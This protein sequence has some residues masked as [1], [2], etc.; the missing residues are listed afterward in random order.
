MKTTRCLAIVL[1]TLIAADSS[2]VHSAAAQTSNT[3]VRPASSVIAE[4]QRSPTEKS[5]DALSVGSQAAE[6]QQAGR[7]KAG[8]DLAMRRLAATPEDAAALYDAGAAA[9][10]VI[11]AGKQE[12]TPQEIGQI[13]EKGVQNL[14]KAI[15]RVRDFTSAMIYKSKLYREQSKLVSDRNEIARLQTLAAA[16]MNDAIQTKRPGTAAVFPRGAFASPPIVVIPVELR[17]EDLLPPGTATF[18]AAPTEV[19]RQLARIVEEPRAT[20][21]AVGQN[22]SLSIDP[23]TILSPNP[24]GYDIAPFLI[25]MLDRLRFS[26]YAVMPEAARRGEKG[27][28]DFIFTIVRDG[29]VQDVKLILTSGNQ[30]LDQAAEAAIQRSRFAPIPDGFKGDQFTLRVPFLYN[31]NPGER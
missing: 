6:Y 1:A 3:A 26:W 31:M 4:L 29:T 8:Y 27:R 23:P 2:G 7:W 18:I 20:P 10:W 25:N 19:P 9:F 12:L 5:D 24:A 17:S 22:S 13:A 11:T 15:S 30:A 14:D 16:A 28:V 21:G